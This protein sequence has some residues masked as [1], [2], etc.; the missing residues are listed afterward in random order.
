MYLQ[1]SS[2][3]DDQRGNP[4]KLEVT[5][6]IYTEH[7]VLNYVEGTG[8]YDAVNAEIINN[9]DIRYKP[10]A[11]PSEFD[12]GLLFANDATTIDPDPNY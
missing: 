1:R 9:L 2:N 12:K 11:I 3:Y 6:S 4:E 8:D 10:F 7:Y 5:E